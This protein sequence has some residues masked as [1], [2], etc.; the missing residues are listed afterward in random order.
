MSQSRHHVSQTCPIKLKPAT[1]RLR[2]D[3]IRLDFQPEE[4]LIEE[5]VQHLIL[6]M[7]KQESLP[8]VTVYWDGEHYYLAD[9]FHR[10]RAA[11]LLHRRTVKAEIKP[12]T[13]QDMENDFA[14]M[15]KAIRKD[16][17]RTSPTTKP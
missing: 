14:D 17:R 6:A 7:E 4:N 15:L 2:I 8:P 16:L 3:S 13:L 1:R 9:G 5:K 12:G 10:V 11:R